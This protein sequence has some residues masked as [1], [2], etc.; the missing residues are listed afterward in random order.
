MALT[1]DALSQQTLRQLQDKAV[2]V[3]IKKPG[4]GWPT[5]CPPDGNKAA[6]VTALVAFYAEQG[7]TTNDKQGMKGGVK[8]DVGEDGGDQDEVPTKPVSSVA[9]RIAMFGALKQQRQP[10]RSSAATVPSL[11]A[12]KVSTDAFE[13]PKPDVSLKPSGKVSD[14]EEV[15]VEEESMSTVA[16]VPS[17]SVTHSTCS[18]PQ[19]Q[20]PSA[21][22]SPS[23]TASA[24]VGAKK[25]IPPP[26][27]SKTMSKSTSTSSTSR[28]TATAPPPTTPRPRASTVVKPTGR[29][30]QLMGK[31]NLQNMFGAGPPVGKPSPQLATPG[32]AS[33]G[34]EDRRDEARTSSSPNVFRD[35]LNTFAAQTSFQRKTQ[36][37][38]ALLVARPRNGDGDLDLPQHHLLGVDAGHA[39]VRLNTLRS[40]KRRMPARMKSS[41]SV[42]Q[43]AGALG[44]STD[45]DQVALSHSTA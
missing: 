23:P 33:A 8:E 2:L 5:C 43:D 31:L 44:Q 35:R 29:V 11:G 22:T 32:A 14:R 42:L 37:T 27:A 24:P 7:G 26:V 41:S 36:S 30:G 1:E 39:R 45:T 34:G 3:G 10:R 40:Q 17:I 15:M 18:P 20:S 13:K 25:K 4:V 21:S 9:A 16:V 6:I 19:S 12:R 38:S 28:A